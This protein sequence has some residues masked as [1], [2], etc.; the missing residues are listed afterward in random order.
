[1]ADAPG[2]ITVLLQ[3]LRDGDRSVIDALM[4]VVYGHLKS[5]AHRQLRGERAGHTLNTTALVHEAYLKLVGQV[6]VEWQNR[7]HFLAVAAQAMRRRL[8]DYARARLAEKRGGGVAVI[9]LNE[10]LHG[11]YAQPEELVALDEALTRLKALDGRQAAVVEYHFFGGL[12]HQEIAEVMGMSEPTVRRD[13]RAAR[14][15]LGVQLRG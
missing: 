8:V 9:T 1:M 11:E 12:T 13:W 2:Q 5:L 6:E 3:R 15:W 7:V 10:E 4:P 14:A